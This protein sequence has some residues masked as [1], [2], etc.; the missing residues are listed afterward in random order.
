MFSSKKENNIPTYDKV[1]TLIG[2]TANFKGNMVAGGTVRVEGCM[3]GEVEIN[4]DIVVGET[5][6]IIGN[7]LASNAHIGGTI[8]GNVIVK[9]QVHLTPSSTV[10]GDI[11]VGNLVVDEGAVF[12]GKCIMANRNKELQD[13]K[14]RNKPENKPET[15]NNGLK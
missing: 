11:E 13:S 8:E 12:T 6:K 14:P 7:V 5:G 4:G 1:E 3:E 9:G 2:K 10:N 15:K